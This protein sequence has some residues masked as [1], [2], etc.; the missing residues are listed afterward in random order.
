[1][2]EE[3]EKTKKAKRVREAKEKKGQK[4]KKIVRLRETTKQQRSKRKYIRNKAHT[5]VFLL[6]FKNIKIN[7]I[8][9]IFL[10]NIAT[11]HFFSIVYPYWGVYCV[12]CVT[13]LL[14]H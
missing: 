4:S 2:S 8:I 10:I 9:A 14:K 5:L 6:M 11:S 7:I 3:K 12:Y 13:P 1:M